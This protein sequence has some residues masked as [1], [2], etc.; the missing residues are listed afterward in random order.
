MSKRKKIVFWIGVTIGILLV[1]LVA[2]ILLLPYLVNLES[3]RQRIIVELSRGTGGEVAFQRIDLSLL[4]RPRVVIHQG[5]LSIPGRIDGTL[6]SLTVYP[7]ILPLLWRQVRVTR[8][9]VESPDIKAELPVKKKEREKKRE[10][11]SLETIPETL[12]PVFALLEEEAPGLVLLVNGGRLQISEGN[13]S[14][15]WFEDI[16]G[17]I[18][19]PPGRLRVDLRC[20]SNLWESLS[21]EGWL[22]SKEFKSNGRLTLIDFQP[23]IL[24]KQFF[25]LASPRLSDSRVNFDLSFQAD[26]SQLFRAELKGSMPLLTVHHGDNKLAF[27]NKSLQA[28]FERDRSA[29]TVTLTELSFD[30]PQLSLSGKLSIDQETPRVSVELEGREVDVASTRQVALALAGKEPTI[31]VIFDLLRGGRVPLITLSSQGSSLADL[32]DLKNIFI[33]GS[34]VDG[35]VF[36]RGSDYGWEGVDLNLEDAKGDVVIS[37]GIIEG[38]NLEARWENEQIREGILKLGLEGED[39]PLHL[40]ALIEIDLSQL[41][42]LLKRL[43]KQ[44]EL[45]AEI[46]RIYGVKGKGVGRLVVGERVDSITVK[47]DVSELN[48][49]ARHEKIPYGLQVNSGQVLYDEQKFGLKDLNGKF[50]KSSFSEVTAQMDFEEAPGLEILSGRFLINLDEIYSWLSSP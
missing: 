31:Q 15:F 42:P 41:D 45:A 47:V 48:L 32:D 5:S 28:A 9:Q 36:I 7:E 19:L 12:A 13:R 24:A 2:L 40:E 50:G 46:G 18:R 8:L 11:V 3:V 21:V 33:M 29:T 34:M 14:I 30:Y 4:P 22:D 1:L 17:S 38:N 16:D 10:A 43:I 39:A 27:K 23:Q 26:G 35:N 25:P 49:F 20:T 37:Q 44:E 6:E